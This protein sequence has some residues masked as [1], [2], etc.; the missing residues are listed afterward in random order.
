MH[1]TY[2]EWLTP[3]RRQITG[4][5]L[6]PDFEAGITDDDRNNGRDPQLDRAIEW[7]KAN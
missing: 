3:N 4:V 1:I 6:T 7:L 5:G 2:A